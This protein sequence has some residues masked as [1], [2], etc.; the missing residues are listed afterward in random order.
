MST[1]TTKTTLIEKILDLTKADP[2]TY[3]DRLSDKSES[4]L[5]KLATVCERLKQ[6]N[7]L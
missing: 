3:F 1:K 6:H 7:A 2:N 5:K 4:Y